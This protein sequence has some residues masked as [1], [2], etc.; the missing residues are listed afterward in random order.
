MIR[1][2][3]IRP[4]DSIGKQTVAGQKKK[5][6]LG[7]LWRITEKSRV[8]CRMTKRVVYHKKVQVVESQNKPVRIEGRILRRAVAKIA[9]GGKRQNPTRVLREDLTLS[10]NTPTGSSAIRFR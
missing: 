4:I 3:R 7:H 5:N 8:L 2:L 1:F 9:T 6:S 10:H